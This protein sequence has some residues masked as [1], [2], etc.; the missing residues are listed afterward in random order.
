M[1]NINEISKLYS[2]GKTLQEIGDVF[3]VCRERIRQV[4]EKHHLPRNTKRSCGGQRW[5]GKKHIKKEM[6]VF[7]E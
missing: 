1:L 4:M 7:D 3:G 2:Q 6:E 5:A